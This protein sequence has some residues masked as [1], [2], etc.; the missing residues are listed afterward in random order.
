MDNIVNKNNFKGTTAKTLS[1]RE[2]QRLRM[3]DI[4]NPVLDNIDIYINGEHKTVEISDAF[5]KI[6]DEIITNCC[7]QYMRESNCKIIDISVSENGSIIIKNNGPGFPIYKENESKYA[8]RETYSVETMLSAQFS[9]TNYTDK[10]KPD[11]ISAGLNG[12]GIKLTN[13]CSKWFEIKTI[14]GGIFYKQIFEGGMKKIHAPQIKNINKPDGT[15]IKF[16]PDYDYICRRKKSVKNKGWFKSVDQI[17]EVINKRAIEI[18]IYLNELEYHTENGSRIYY[19]KKPKIKFCGKT[20]K[21]LSLHEWAKS[22]KFGTVLSYNLMGRNIPRPFKFAISIYDN[23]HRKKFKHFS[24]VNGVVTTEEGNYLTELIKQI[25]AFIKPKFIDK[26]NQEFSAIVHLRNL[27]A[28]WSIA[29]VPKSMLNFKGQFKSKVTLAPD[30]KKQWNKWYKLSNKILNEIWINLEPVL[31]KIVSRKKQRVKKVEAG[32]Y[33]P[34]TKCKNKNANCTLIVVE[35]NSAATLLQDIIKANKD[36]STQTYGI[37]SIQGVPINAL[38]NTKYINGQPIMNKKLANNKALQAMAQIIGLDYNI[39]YDKKSIKSLNYKSIIISTDQDTDGIGKICSLIICFIYVYFPELIKF[40]FIRRYR[41]PIV[42]VYCR[43]KPVA[44]YGFYSEAEYKIFHNNHKCGAAHDV[45]FYKGLGTHTTA[46][47]KHMAKTFHKDLLLYYDDENSYDMM[48]KMHGSDTAFR[49]FILRDQTIKDYKE[50][51]RVSITEQYSIASKEQQLENIRRMI[52]EIGD[53]FNPV[54]RKIF[55]TIRGWR[56]SQVNKVFQLGGETAKK[57]KYAH[58]DASINGAIMGLA[59]AVPGLNHVPI[60]RPVSGSIGSQIHG[61]KGNAQPRYTDVG[62]NLCTDYLFP[63]ADDAVLQYEE[64]E[65]E[66]CEPTFYVSVLPRILFEHLQTVATGWSYKIWGRQIDKLAAYTK[67]SIQNYPNT[68]FPDLIGLVWVWEGMNIRIINGKEYCFGEYKLDRDVLYITQ[69]PLQSWSHNYHLFLQGLD[70]SGKPVKNNRFEGVIKSIEHDNDST[71]V[72]FKIKLMPGWQHIVNKTITRDEIQPIEKFFKLYVTLPEILN[73]LKKGQVIEYESRSDIWRDWFELRRELYITRIEY[74]SILV[75]AK[76]DM[77]KNI[78]KFINQNTGQYKGMDR[79]ERYNKWEVAG[80]LKLNRAAIN[81]P[82]NCTPA[83]L[84]NKIY[85]L[86]SNYSYI[87]D[88]RESWYSKNE[89]NKIKNRIE[90]LT[91]ELNKLKKG[92]KNIWISEIDQLMEKVNE[93][94]KTGWSY[95]NAKIKFL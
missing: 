80:F 75:T 33:I 27:I 46:E 72:Y 93:G 11:S 57:K 1:F 6:V 74:Q 81:N 77:W 50:D 89:Q 16:M 88:I 42:R 12:L 39:K 17:K 29:L 68:Y 40:G 36:L 70:S 31:S 34:A 69:L 73:F 38:R 23:P 47:R 9:S 30:D 21:N 13:I 51:Q 43:R 7:D 76:I 60:I 54:H 22:F 53:G 10:T 2:Y 35:G 85:K 19:R 79:D 61:R 8:D 67:I 55:A 62:Y 58:G 84:K 71:S 66:I 92:W 82:G 83:E 20:I 4:G 90:K 3:N 44:V 25:A 15:V 56:H 32:L 78:I 14:T 5:I 45:K 41:T 52:P 18:M 26:F 63:K 59:Q 64:V 94:I 95:S 91:A 28:V 24:I 48:V 86:D 87:D 37:Y 65:G 49:K